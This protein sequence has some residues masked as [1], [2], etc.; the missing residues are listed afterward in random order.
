MSIESSVVSAHTPYIAVDEDYDKPIEGAIQTWDLSATM[1]A[2]EGHFG[3][4]MDHSHGRCGGSGT[5][6]NN[7]D[8]VDGSDEPLP[9]PSYLLSYSDEPS[10]SPDDSLGG[11]CSRSSGSKRSSFRASLTQ[12]FGAG[13]PPVDSLVDFLSFDSNRP[14]QQFQQAAPLTSHSMEKD[15]VT[16]GSKLHQTG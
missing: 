1:A 7:F 4:D 15:K 3:F 6:L 2:S 10:S 13:T 14:K 16:S 12:A 9:L 11:L 5:S 8:D